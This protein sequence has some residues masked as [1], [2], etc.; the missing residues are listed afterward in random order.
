MAS[1]GEKVRTRFFI[2]DNACTTDTSTFDK[3]TRNIVRH[4]FNGRKQSGVR[5]AY[6]ASVKS[7]GIVESVRGE[8]WLVQPQ[9]AGM[10]YRALSFA[11]LCEAYYAAL[12]EDPANQNLLVSLVKGLECRIL[13]RRLPASIAKYLINM[14]NRFHSGS[15]TSFVEL[16][17]LVPDV[18]LLES[19]G[20]SDNWVFDTANKKAQVHRL[21]TLMTGSVVTTG[22]SKKGSNKRK[23]PNKENT[24]PA[25]KKSKTRG[26][27]KAKAKAAPVPSVSVPEEANISNTTIECEVGVRNKLWVD[28][29]I[30]CVGHV[31]DA[32][33]K[34]LDDPSPLADLKAHLFRSG[35]LFA[36]NG[37]IVLPT[38]AGTKQHKR[39]SSLRPALTQHA[40]WRVMQACWAC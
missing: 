6:I 10:P 12:V 38:A 37:S 23:G 14:H 39:W 4:E 15:S 33:S 21:F 18:P 7:R 19:A 24:N 32:V 40:V 2:D 29:L 16:V 35:L 17:Q 30:S 11:S 36:M 5:K 13:D 25:A 34:M 22:A 1:V 27:A 9:D 26:G 28:D 3:R 31:T 8:P 20:G